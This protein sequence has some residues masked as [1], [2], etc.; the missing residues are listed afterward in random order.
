MTREYKEL[1]KFI[2]SDE[3]EIWL[4][5]INKNDYA[6][7]NPFKKLILLNI[8]LLITQSITH[9]YLHH[10]LDLYEKKHEPKINRKENLFV[11]RMTVKEIKKIA[12]YILK[13]CELKK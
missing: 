11:D 8:Y 1:M 10:K 5:W 4:G 3:Y 6:R 7:L 12:K 9:E 13:N 2:K